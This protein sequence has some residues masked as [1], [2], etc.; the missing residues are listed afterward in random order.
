VISAQKVPEH[1]SNFLSGDFWIKS[2]FWLL[3]LPL[4]AL[5]YILVYV[6]ACMS[7]IKVDRLGVSS[8]VNPYHASFVTVL[9]DC[10]MEQH[11]GTQNQIWVH[12][13]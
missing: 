12:E 3:F 7:L 10:P 6:W 11:K 4:S 13:N 9:I 1:C 5:S 2:N 8:I